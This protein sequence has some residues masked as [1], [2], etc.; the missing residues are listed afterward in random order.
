[1]DAMTGSD[2]ATTEAAQV[3]T[4]YLA[5]HRVD[6]HG[7]FTLRESEIVPIA[8]MFKVL[9][10]VEV[11]DGFV[12]GHLNRDAEL[13]VETQQHSPGGLGINQFAGPVTISMVDLLYLSLAWSDNTASDLL[14]PYVGLEALHARAKGLSLETVHIV[15]DCRALL[16]NAGKDLG[17]AT[18]SIAAEHDWAPPTDDADLVLRHTTRASTSDLA[19][20][21]IHLARG[22][23][24][25]PEACR[26]VRDLMSRQVWTARFARAFP[27]PQW[28]RTGKTGTLQPWR[29]EF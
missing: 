14:L 16:R 13:R 4:F 24:A 8:S 23:A 5:C 10:A 19:R 7:S 15:G 11:A 28:T 9:L 18:E 1:M 22:T 27:S 20:L 25:R 17:Y 3:G 2:A 6:E 21:A 26:L 12:Q 29:G